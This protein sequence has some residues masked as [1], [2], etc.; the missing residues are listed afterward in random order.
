MKEVE[1]GKERGKD[2]RLSKP[3]GGNERVKERERERGRER[4]LPLAPA[5]GTVF[6]NEGLEAHY[7]SQMLP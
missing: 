7:C 4:K 1:R 6:G 2:E 3:E 5:Q